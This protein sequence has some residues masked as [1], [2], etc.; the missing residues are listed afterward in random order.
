LCTIKYRDDLGSILSF[1]KKES[2][3]TK[4]FFNLFAQITL[5]INGISTRLP[6]LSFLVHVKNM[7]ERERERETERERE[8]EREREL[9]SRD[10]VGS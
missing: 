8:R 2:V 4:F 1:W 7:R 10:P 9:L 3:E 6:E 5:E